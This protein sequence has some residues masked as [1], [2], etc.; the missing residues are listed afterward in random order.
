MD[1]RFWSSQWGDQIFFSH[2]TN[3]SAGVAI[4][5]NNF[6][7]KILT[8]SEDSFGHWI[9]CVS[10]VDDNFLIIGNIYGYNNYTQNKTMFAEITKVVKVKRILLKMSYW[11]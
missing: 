4:L 2:G 3:R 1:E 6:P 8:T 11:W 9:I 10:E 7:G 5:L